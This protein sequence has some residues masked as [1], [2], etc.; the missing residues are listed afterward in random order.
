MIRAA[1]V[2]WNPA[3]CAA[4][5]TPLSFVP[6]PFPWGKAL[7]LFFRRSAAAFPTPVVKGA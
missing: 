5:F 7:R 3:R 1:L 6:V 4:F 2:L